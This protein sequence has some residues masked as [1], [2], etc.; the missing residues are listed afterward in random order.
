MH[1]LFLCCTQT[2]PR[3]STARQNIKTALLLKRGFGLSRPLRIQ[4][5][6]QLPC[7]TSGRWRRFFERLD[8]FLDGQACIICGELSDSH[9][10]ALSEDA[11]EDYV[12]RYQTVVAARHGDLEGLRNVYAAQKSLILSIDGIQPEKGHETLY[13]VRELTQRWVWFAEPLL[14]SRSIRLSASSPGCS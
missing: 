8:L 11:V 9:R 14:P 7:R 12:R 3:K 6:R 10:I 2:T 4:A 13:V 5:G 1:R